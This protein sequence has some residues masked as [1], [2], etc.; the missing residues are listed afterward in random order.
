MFGSESVNWRM[1][2]SVASQAFKHGACTPDGIFRRNPKFGGFMHGNKKRT[3]VVVNP[4]GSK[5]KYC[6]GDNCRVYLPLFQFGNNCN[7]P[8]GL[9]TYCIECNN[10]KRKEKDRRRCNFGCVDD[11]VADPPASLKPRMFTQ[12]MKRD[13]LAVIQAKIEETGD[14]LG[15]EKMPITA[16]TIYDKLFT[17][18]RWVCE[19]TN[20][21]MTPA[22]F[23]DHHTIKF[24]IEDGRLNV[25][26]NMCTMP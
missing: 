18:R 13:V 5:M 4:D 22:C 21:T 14:L 24:M 1:K 19:R 10:R 16:T 15:W 6:P 7:M 9:D 12:V 11:S 23:I 25:K 8:D 17:G 20:Q 3:S 2:E 26:C